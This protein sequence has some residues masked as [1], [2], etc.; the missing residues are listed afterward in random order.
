LTNS[1][2]MYATWK[3][4][5][6]LTASKGANVSSVGSSP[7]CSVYNGST[8]GC[9]VT[10]PTI[11]PNAGYTSVGWSATNG[12]TSG[13]TG[14]VTLTSNITRYGNATDQTA[15]TCGTVTNG[16]TTWRTTSQTISVACSETGGSGCSQT[17]FSGTFTQT[18]IGSITIKDK[19]GNTKS[20]SVSAYVD[21][22]APAI[23]CTNISGGTSGVSLT[24][25]AS[26]G[27]SGL[28]TDPS[29]S[30]SGVKSTT[31]YTAK[32]GAGLTKSCKVTVT[33]TATTWKKTRAA[34][35][36]GNYGSGTTTYV[37]TCSTRSKATADANN[38]SSYW[39]C[40]SI[41]VTANNA[42][43]ACTSHNLTAPCYAKTTY[44]RTSCKTW[45]S[46]SDYQTGLTSC[47]GSTGTLYKYVCVET[48]W[49]YSGS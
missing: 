47:S 28:V 11:T 34:C 23:S 14:T 26:D 24:V 16:S 33:K 10:Y 3:K 17:S 40:N 12:A 42:S 22:T 1:F 9:S 15:P 19:A 31:T 32:N 27:V 43:Q 48:A 38:Y 37:K 44:N 49:T 45:G 25:T 36:A 7:S 35:T 41:S 30:K 18:K 29:G 4:T 20:C 2:T 8:S 13:S 5:F 21:T 46:A 39:S 6:K